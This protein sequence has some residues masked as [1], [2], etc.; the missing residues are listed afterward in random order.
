MPSGAAPSAA[1]SLIVNQFHIVMVFG[2]VIAHEQR[3]RLFTR[4]T[5]S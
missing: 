4:F 1:P 5:L 3:L 2:P